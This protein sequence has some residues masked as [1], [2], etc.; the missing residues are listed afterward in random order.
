MGVQCFIHVHEEKK[1]NSNVLFIPMKKKNVALPYEL[2]A[3]LSSFL[4]R[5]KANSSDALLSP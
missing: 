2:S 4:R 5:K 1:T 3:S